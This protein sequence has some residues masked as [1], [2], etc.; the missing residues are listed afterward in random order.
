M[1]QLL[2]RDSPARRWLVPGL[3]G[4]LLLLGLLLVRDYG[5]S[6][7]AG[8]SR[9]IGMT[10][11][12]Y[13]AEKI[14]PDF[15]TRPSQRSYFEPFST[16]LPDFVDRDYGVAYELPVTLAERLLGLAEPRSIF[17]FRHACTLLVSWV[18]VLALY[19]LG[20]R[21]YGGDWRLGLAAAGLLVLSPRL[22]GEFFYNDKDAVFMALSTVATLT[23]VRLL[24][25]PTGR[26]A[27]THAL[28][29][30]LAIDVR[31][32]AVLWPLAT[33]GLL[34]WRVAWG[35]YRT[36]PGGVRRALGALAVYALLLPPLVVA[37]WPYL[38]A[39]PWANFWQAFANM[40]HFRWG[41]VVL[42]RGELVSALAL[43]WHYAPTWLA[44][45]TPLPQLALMGLG[46]G[47]VGQQ[48][49]RRGRRLYAAGTREW[50][51]LL[52]LGL[53]LGP[54]VAVIVF[55][56]TLYDGWR[57]LYFVYPS[58]LLLAVRGLVAAR[59]GL[60]GRPRWQGQL[61]TGALGLGLLSAAGQLIWLHPFQ[62]LYFN[63]LAGADVGQRYEQDYWGISYGAGLRWVLAHDE[64]AHVRVC[65]EPVMGP[66]LYLNYQ[67]LPPAGQARLELVPR[68]EDADY[69]L[70]NYRWHPGAYDLPPEVGSIRAGRQRI[71]SI[72]RLRW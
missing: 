36:L 48:L 71:L 51:D 64:R 54:I 19:G 25:R 39:A 66:S 40:Q 34:A 15:V 16:P 14:N 37:G 8:Q 30:A 20:R 45:T 22:V 59:R 67:L 65:T 28:A 62:S 47:V 57:Q 4:G 9:L 33:A 7:D 43:P 23:T 60:A 29:C 52:F 3:L 50:Q 1:R 55:R 24:E 44:L 11:L 58:L 46:L 13:V 31:L 21:R 12:R 61:A 10:S 56:S 6:Y 18:G 70:T 63:V 53:G 69:F 38:W 42:Y 27:A 35:D 49:G 2:A 72:F 68:P 41:G 32:M 17:W 5:L 26:R